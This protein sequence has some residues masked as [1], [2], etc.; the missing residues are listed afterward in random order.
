MAKA[1]SKDPPQVDKF[2]QLALDVECDDDEEAF[3]AKF[4]KVASVPKPEPKSEA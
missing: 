1:K 3:R 2:R 4:R